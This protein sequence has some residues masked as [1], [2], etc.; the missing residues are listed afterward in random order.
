[1]PEWR[2]DPGW[3][4][5]SKAATRLS[6]VHAADCS[7]VAETWDMCIE[8]T[9]RKLAYGALAGGLAAMVLFRTPQP[10]SREAPLPLVFAPSRSTAAPTASLLPSPRPLTSDVAATRTGAPSARASVLGLGAGV[11]VGMG[12]SDC[13]YEFDDIAKAEKES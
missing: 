2:C 12:Y 4:S 3:C 6:H 1:M 10:R 7:Q 5:D 11:G 9:V 8:N 13:K